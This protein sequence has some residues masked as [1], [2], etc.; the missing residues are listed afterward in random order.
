M[1]KREKTGRGRTYAG[2]TALRLTALLSGAGGAEIPVQRQGNV[3]E[4]DHLAELLP[5]ESPEAKNRDREER[6][7]ALSPP[8]PRAAERER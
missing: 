4:L 7:P 1:K 5:A 3:V 6:I 8:S 2:G